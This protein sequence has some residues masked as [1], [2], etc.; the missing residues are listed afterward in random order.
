MNRAGATLTGAVLAGALWALPVAILMPVALVL[1]YGTPW[2]W[3]WLGFAA[4]SAAAGVLVWR[5]W[6]RRPL[7]TAPDRP[8]RPARDAQE[9]EAWAAIDRVAEAADPAMLTDR[10]QALGFAV[11]LVDAVARVYRPDDRRP[12]LATTV[13]ELLLL[14]ERVSARVRRLVLTQ[15]P[16]GDSVRI[17]QVARVADFAPHW[18]HVRTAYGVWRAVRAPLN[19]LAAVLGEMRDWATR[20]LGDAALDE[21]GRRILS[22]LVAEI[23]QAAIDLYSGRLRLSPEEVAAAGARDVA[24]AEGEAAPP[25]R[26]LLIGPSGAGKSTLINALA[27]GVRAAVDSLPTTADIVPYAVSVADRPAV[28]LLDSPGLDG[29]ARTEKRLREAAARADLILAVTPAHRPGRAEEAAFAARL[30][31][32]PGTGGPVPPMLAVVT[33]IDR[34]PP[35][36]EWAPPYALPSPDALDTQPASDA[37]PRARKARAITGALEQ[38]A[39]DLDLPADR[40]VAAVPDAEAGRSGIDDVWAA[41]AAR[42][43]DAQ[44]KAL[45]RHLAAGG[46]FDPVRLAQQAVGAG[47]LL[48]GLV[49]GTGGRDRPAGSHRSTPGAHSREDR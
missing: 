30:R 15:V 47:R 13:P 1:L 45:V 41:L 25:P 3:A 24:A 49:G 11:D 36:G 6:R 44:A 5:R 29:T 10:A 27:D 22:I 39:A 21:A 7:E 18:R 14:S 48:G 37:S 40:V 38:A 2:F 12:L 32:A 19:P 4:L 31:E 23:G 16:F 35:H 17:G 20:A 33:H 34:L 9:A 8:D 46:R 43:P 42:L 28:I 26:I